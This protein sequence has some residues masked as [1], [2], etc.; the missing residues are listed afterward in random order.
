MDPLNDDEL[1]RLLQT[2]Q[3]PQAPPSL[4]RRVLPTKIPL[5]RRVFSTSFRVPAPIAAAAAIVIVLLLI[6]RTPPARPDAPPVPSQR[7]TSLAE[8]QPVRRLEPIL[9]T[10]GQSR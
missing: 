8:F 2:W 4:S 7:T 3:A 10:G 9:V 5:W 6:Y 1:K